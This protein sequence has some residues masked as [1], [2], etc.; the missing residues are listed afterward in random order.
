MP[1][2][3]DPQNLINGILQVY[4][5]AT[6]YIGALVVDK[7]G[8]RTLFLTSAAGMCASYAVWTA[9]AATYAQ[10]YTS[11]DANGYPI[12]ANTS[13][14]NGVLAAIFFYYG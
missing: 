5:L 12:G 1:P 7:A 14:G 13:A 3:A 6:A 2:P 9:C 8:R 4:N 10:S 11:V